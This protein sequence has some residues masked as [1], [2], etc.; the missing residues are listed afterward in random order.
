MMKVAVPMI[1]WIGTRPALNLAV[2]LSQASRARKLNRP[3]NNCKMELYLRRL[4]RC[5]FGHL[6]CEQP[7]SSKPK[8]GVD[9]VEMRK[10]I[11]PETLEVPDSY[12]AQS[13]AGDGEKVEQ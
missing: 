1:A 11:C 13:Y 6:N 4:L 12:E 2:P 9:A 10:W 8:P 7:H 3:T 5:F